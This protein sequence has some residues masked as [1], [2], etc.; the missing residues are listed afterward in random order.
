MPRQALGALHPGRLLPG[1]ARRRCAIGYHLNQGADREGEFIDAAQ[2]ADVFFRPDLIT[3]RLAGDEAAI[4]QACRSIGDVR[5][6]LAGGLPPK[7]TLLSPATADSTAST[8]CACAS[9][10]AG[11]G[12]RM[13]ELKL[14]INGAEVPSRAVSP[15]GGGVVTQRLPLGA[16]HQ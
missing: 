1:L 10:P 13:G 6:V 3:R 8:S 2:L 4:A 11:A 5:A 7:V 9:N 16:G 14:F 12:G 15:P